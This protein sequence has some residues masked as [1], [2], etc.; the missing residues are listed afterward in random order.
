MPII[1][2]LQYVVLGSN[3]FIRFA[4]IYKRTFSCIDI[5]V[6]CVPKIYI[7]CVLEDLRKYLIK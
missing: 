4:F 6:T 1:A 5:Y 3:M 7:S 2:H